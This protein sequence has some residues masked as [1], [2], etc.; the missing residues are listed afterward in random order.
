MTQRRGRLRV[1]IS[2]SGVP[3]EASQ[4]Y[5]PAPD[6]A[7]PLVPAD[8]LARRCG[9]AVRRRTV[10][11]GRRGRSGRLIVA[12]TGMS[13]RLPRQSGC[14]PALSRGHL[15]ILRLAAVSRE[16]GSGGGSSRLRSGLAARTAGRSSW[17]RSWALAGAGRRCAGGDRHGVP[18]GRCRLCLSRQRRAGRSEHGGRRG[19]AAT[20][21]LCGGRGRASRVLERRY[22]VVLPDHGC[23]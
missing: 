11:D 16:A 21:R 12:L 10:Y 5:F 6:Y 15:T 17:R 13:C 4:R 20:P 9:A 19:G 7:G 1:Q 14:W 2:H 8:G 22:L 18:T 23:R 3:F